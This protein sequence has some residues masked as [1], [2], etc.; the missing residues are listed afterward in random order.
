MPEQS[1]PPYADGALVIP[2]QLQRW[3]DVNPQNGPLRRTEKYISVPSFDV[4][5]VWNGYSEIVG[6]YHFEAPNNFS[7]KIPHDGDVIDIN[8]NYTM[9][10]S[11]VNSDH[12]VVRYSLIRGTGDL[13]YFTLE[14]Y[15]GQLIKKNFRIEIWNTSQVTC[16]ETLV[17]NIYTSVLGDQDY[18]YGVDSALKQA[19]P[20]CTGQQS[21]EGTGIVMPAE[22][23]LLAWL[24]AGYTVSQV[25]PDSWVDRENDLN[26]VGNSSGFAV[27]APNTAVLQSGQTFI[28][29]T[30][31]NPSVFLFHFQFVADTNNNTI[32]QVTN[33]GTFNVTIQPIAG[34]ISVSVSG[35]LTNQVG[36]LV[37]GTEYIAVITTTSLGGT[38]LSVYLAHGLTLIGSNNDPSG[39]DFGSVVTQVGT[40]NSN[41]FVLRT[42]G[43]LMYSG[44]ANDDDYNQT[45]QYMSSLLNYSNNNPQSM[46]LPFTW[47]QCAQPTLNV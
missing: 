41:G 7:L 3:L 1:H 29:G 18:R 45:L 32:L 46:L 5:H 39:L 24:D 25:A 42:R 11:Y 38:T 4:D 13:F 30:L 12:T 36:G 26:F 19:D 17:T 34:T 27:I 22:T 20:L 10:V 31:D 44:I 35:G 9:C 15:A 6:E 40:S 16:S 2:R 47:G 37:G 43:I 21:V 8:T 33:F 14:P 23:N 28:Y